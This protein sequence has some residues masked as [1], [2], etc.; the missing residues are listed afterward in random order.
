[1]QLSAL[2]GTAVLDSGDN[3]FK[4]I[5]EG[6]ELLVGGVVVAGGFD[7]SAG[8]AGVAGF[9]VGAGL[10]PGIDG[11]VIGA[12]LLDGV[13]VVV[14][15][16][17]DGGGVIGAALL[18]GIVVVGVDGVVI[19]AAVFDGAVEFVVLFIALDDAGS[20]FW[21]GVVGLGFIVWTGGAALSIVVVSAKPCIQ[22]KE[23][24][25][26]V[27]SLDLFIDNTPLFKL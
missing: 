21:F 10:F 12:E 8:V 9:V 13:V 18:D 1:M 3:D 14:V 17:D 20:L 7:G 25:P 5:T 4:G 19:G 27:N 22:T 16:V 23:N 11:V 6:A 24:N 2:V 15:D 26:A